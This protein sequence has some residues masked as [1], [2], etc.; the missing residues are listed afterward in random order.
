MKRRILFLLFIFCSFVNTSAFGG[1]SVTVNGI[2]VQSPIYENN[3][4]VTFYPLRE[5]SQYLGYTVSWNETLQTV[6]VKGNSIKAQLKLGDNSCIV[7]GDMVYLL[8]AP[9]V[10]I[11]N[12]TYVSSDFFT[13]ALSVTIEQEGEITAFHSPKEMIHEISGTIVDAA[14]HTLVIKT[15]EGSVYEFQTENADKSHCNGLL[16]GTQAKV[17]YAG[18]LED[19]MVC[20][21][22]V[23]QPVESPL[24]KS[25]AHKS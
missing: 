12:Y 17:T 4:A 6:Q 3:S 9:A 8:D 18:D 14:M 7:D 24:E 21:I 10:C 1:E 22:F 16:L 15:Q 11:E 13:D 25:T 20:V 2:V 19:G 5:V 23:C